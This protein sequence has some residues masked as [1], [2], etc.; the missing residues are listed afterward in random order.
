MVTKCVDGARLR[1]PPVVFAIIGLSLVLLAVPSG[2]ALAVIGLVGAAVAVL[3]CQPA[4]AEHSVRSY[5]ANRPR[6]G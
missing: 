4:A 1:W 2:I 5:G 6:H 3:V